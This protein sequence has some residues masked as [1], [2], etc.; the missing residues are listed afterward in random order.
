MTCKS[1][2]A[3]VSLSGGLVISFK[4]TP[5]KNSSAE[6]FSEET[7]TFSKEAE[8]SECLTGELTDR[9]CLSPMKFDTSNSSAVPSGV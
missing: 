5:L 2:G 7:E 3:P 9:S 6:M 8:S 4:E 1:R